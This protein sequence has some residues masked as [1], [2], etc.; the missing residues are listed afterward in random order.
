MKYLLI[1]INS[2]LISLG[3][4]EILFATFFGHCL[5]DVL[6]GILLMSVGQMFILA[7]MGQKE[8]T[9]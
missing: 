6:V 5:I 1:G 2:L 9:E 8:K 3:I 4:A 7:T